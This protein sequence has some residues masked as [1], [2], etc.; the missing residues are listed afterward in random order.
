[1]FQTKDPEPMWLG[2]F[3]L[4][5]PRQPRQ[6]TLV[7]LSLIVLLHTFDFHHFASS[8]LLMFTVFSTS[9]SYNILTLNFIL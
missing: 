7:C 9:T 8:S 3:R 1:M 2:H 4:Q 6:V 5:D